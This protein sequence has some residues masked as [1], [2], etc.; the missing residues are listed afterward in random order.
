MITSMI[1]SALLLVLV[2]AAVLFES[3][4]HASVGY[5]DEF[6]FHEGNDPQLG[7]CVP[8]DA[9]LSVNHSTGAS[10]KS[11]AKRRKARTETVSVDQGSPL[12]YQI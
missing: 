3:I 7:A 1:I 11:R 6:G 12:T 8:H 10:K 2:A 4:R 9:I 5:Q